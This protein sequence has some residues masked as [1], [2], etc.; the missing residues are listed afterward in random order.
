M[1]VF[2]WV[3]SCSATSLEGDSINESLRLLSYAER[4]KIGLQSFTWICGNHVSAGKK[5]LTAAEFPCP[6]KLQSQKGIFDVELVNHHTV[7]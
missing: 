3:E 5:L 4:V 7:F 1:E 2:L 6:C